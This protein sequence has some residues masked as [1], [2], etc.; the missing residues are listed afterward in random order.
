MGI[1]GATFVP[2]NGSTL[3]GISVLDTV[4]RTGVVPEKPANDR[5]HLRNRE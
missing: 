4:L 5:V 3:A 1:N 2:R